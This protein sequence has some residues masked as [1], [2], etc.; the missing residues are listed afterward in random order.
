MTSRVCAQCAR[1]L[2]VT[3]FSVRPDGTA[4]RVCDRCREY[5][6]GRA[7]KLNARRSSVP[8]GKKIQRVRTGAMD[9]WTEWHPLPFDVLSNMP[10]DELN[11]YCRWWQKANPIRWDLI[12]ERL[13]SA[14]REVE[15]TPNI[16]GLS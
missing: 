11:E 2:P 3:A 15:R 4:F 7:R 10:D 14:Y 12:A 16:E 5:R 8:K 13:L 9:G 1:I 6:K